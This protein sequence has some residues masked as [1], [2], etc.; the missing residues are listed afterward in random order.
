MLKTVF[1]TGVY[2]FALIFMMS[3]SV[4]ASSLEGFSSSKSA[5]DFD[6]TKIATIG[7][8]Q[9]DQEERI[10]PDS[11]VDQKKKNEKAEEVKTEPAKPAVITYTVVSGDSL[12]KIAEAN[13]TTWNRLFDKNTQVIDQNS[14]N[15]GD[16]LTIPAVDEVLA[17]RPVV[18]A[19]PVAITYAPIAQGTIRARSTGSVQVQPA[20]RGSS[21]GNTYASGYCTWYAKSRR[22]DLPNRLGNANTW[23]ARA[24]AQG[25]ATGSAPRAGAIGQQGMH[26]V[27]V[28]S[29][30]GD[31]T[32]TVSE[33]NWKGFGV[34]SSRTVA[35][36]NFTYIY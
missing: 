34:V 9:S 35:A 30:N 22:P 20:P 7:S 12:T 21:A 6:V 5:I 4:G 32:V 18:E 23:V 29:V 13:Q 2:S 26:V 27:Y 19:A 25:I 24:A 17:P 3:S 14:I 1:K 8:R 33:M 11:T 28:E 36:S 15:P 31:G 10:K 16:V